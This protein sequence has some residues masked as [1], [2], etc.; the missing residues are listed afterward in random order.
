[1]SEHGGT[2]SPQVTTCSAT[3]CPF[4]LLFPVLG[5]FTTLYQFDTPDSFVLCYKGGAM[6]VLLYN[7][8]PKAPGKRYKQNRTLSVKDITGFDKQ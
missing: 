4:K 2:R 3:P 1:M 5:R 6:T 7:E 8:E